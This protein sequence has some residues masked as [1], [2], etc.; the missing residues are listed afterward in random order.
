[1]CVHPEGQ[2]VLVSGVSSSRWF[3]IDVTSRDVVE[4]HSDAAERIDCIEYSP[5]NTGV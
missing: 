4:S 5:G 2:L 1:M 3:V